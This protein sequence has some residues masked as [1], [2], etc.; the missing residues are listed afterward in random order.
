M[1]SYGARMAPALATQHCPTHPISFLFF[2]L[3]TLDFFAS[4]ED[5]VAVV[6]RPGGRPLLWLRRSRA[7]PFVVQTAGPPQK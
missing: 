7:R 4:L 6:G 1:L 2:V 5:F 3:Q